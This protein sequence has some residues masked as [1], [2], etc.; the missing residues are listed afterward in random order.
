MHFFT[1]NR[2]MGSSYRQVRTVVINCV[3][4]SLRDVLGELRCGPVRL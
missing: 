3:L 4:E 2:N 1:D